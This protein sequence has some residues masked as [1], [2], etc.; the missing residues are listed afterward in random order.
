MWLGTTS[1][2]IMVY[3]GTSLLKY[4]SFNSGL[5]GDATYDIFISDNDIIWVCTSAGVSAF[6]GTTWN[7]Y[8]TENSSL[9]VNQSISMEDD[10]IGRYWVGTQGGVIDGLNGRVYN[11]SNSILPGDQVLEIELASDTSLFFGTDRGFGVLDGDQWFAYPTGVGKVPDAAIVAFAEDTAGCMWASLGQGVD[12]E[13]YKLCNGDWDEIVTDGISYDDARITSIVVQDDG[14]IWMGTHHEGV[15]LFKDAE[16]SQFTTENSDLSIN[17]IMSM[18]IDS[19]GN[20]WLGSRDGLH[21]VVQAVNEEGVEA[22]PGKV[23]IYPNP[24]A[25]HFTVEAP[26]NDEISFELFN[27]YGDIVW[28]LNGIRP[29]QSVYFPPGITPG[30]YHYRVLCRGAIYPGT[31]LKISR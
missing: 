28:K 18:A 27:Y 3:D 16:W 12:G 4:N 20:V 14:A 11:K 6:D 21:R 26:G 25:D 7:S 29:G 2:G 9:P 10:D 31:V 13:L 22:D 24:V 30:I 1:D 19:A 17:Q 15:L 8:T 23:R 5:L